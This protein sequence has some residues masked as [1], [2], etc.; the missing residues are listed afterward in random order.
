MSDTVPSSATRKLGGRLLSLTVIATVVYFVSSVGILH[1]LRPDIDPVAQG[2]SYY[3]RGPY[4]SLMNSAFAAI[5]V[6]GLALTFGLYQTTTARGKSSSGLLLLGIWGITQIVAAIFPIELPGEPP[7]SAGMIHSLVGFSFVLIGPATLLLAR[8]FA[9]DPYWATFSRQAML[10]AVGILIAS[11]MLFIFNGILQ[12]LRFGG[13]A[14]RAYWLSI[15]LWLVAAAL[16]LRQAPS[17]HVLA[18]GGDHD[19]GA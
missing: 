4:N 16:W 17:A 8:R 14:Q 1:F 13:I 7:T 19:G 6:A 9:N 11:V 10:I 18:S 15:V 3:G 12:P 2:L 5:G